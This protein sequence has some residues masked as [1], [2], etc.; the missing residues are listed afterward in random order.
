MMKVKLF[1]LGTAL[2]VISQS[3]GIATGQSKGVASPHSS[4][5][6]RFS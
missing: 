5:P 6:L 3:G 2:I 4:I 1:A